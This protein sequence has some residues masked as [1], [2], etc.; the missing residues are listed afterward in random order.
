MPVY[1]HIPKIKCQGCASAIKEALSKVDGIGDFD[2][3]VEK[4]E[5]I[6]DPGKANLDIIKEA[7]TQAGYL[8]E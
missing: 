4:R 5:V 6:V 3:D 2:V 7:L 8:P 1:L